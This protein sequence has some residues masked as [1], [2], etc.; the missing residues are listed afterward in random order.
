M[1]I[2]LKRALIV[3]TVAFSL[4]T[5]IPVL[6][7]SPSQE[8]MDCWRVLENE[9]SERCKE[10]IKNF[11]E[12]ERSFNAQMNSVERR[13]D[14]SPLPI[15]VKARVVKFLDRDYAERKVE[16]MD[17]DRP[18]MGTKNVGGLVSSVTGSDFTMDSR[19]AGLGLGREGATTTV[20]VTTSAE[21]VFKKNGKKETNI[22]DL[23]VG[24]MVMVIGQFSTSTKILT[25]KR[26]DIMT[27]PSGLEK[28]GDDRRLAS[29]TP[30]MNASST[31][32]ALTQKMRD[33]IQSLIDKLTRL[34]GR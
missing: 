8:V 5:G 15:S 21:T 17:R 34:L 18:M 19:G 20:F 1:N 3:G 24:N 27:L 26:V 16:M 12:T 33:N 22:S 31:R 6:A 10:I 25:A 30:M 14:I 28:R 13:G 11:E 32:P 29:G 4:A 23:A 2:K 9:Q 7:L